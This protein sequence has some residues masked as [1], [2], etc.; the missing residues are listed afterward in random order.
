MLSDAFYLKLAITCKNFFLSLI[1][2]CLVIFYLIKTQPDFVANQAPIPLP[3]KNKP[4]MVQPRNWPSNKPKSCSA[5]FLNQHFLE[6][7]EFSE[8]IN[9]MMINY[10]TLKAELTARK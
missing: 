4:K 3:C 9:K 1:V 10:V 6:K 8:F 5:T 2:V 7:M